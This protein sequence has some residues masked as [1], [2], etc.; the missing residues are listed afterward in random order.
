MSD[1]LNQINRPGPDI[2]AA[3]MAQL[4]ASMANLPEGKNV[5]VGTIALTP[6]MLGVG[7]GLRTE[8]GWS[9]V[10]N[11]GVTRAEK[12]QAIGAVTIVKTW[13]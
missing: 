4:K 5:V 13:D 6:D 8:S 12:P 1:I 10:G 2:L 11:V 9:I 3:G 7:I